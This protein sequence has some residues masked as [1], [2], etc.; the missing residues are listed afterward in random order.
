MSLKIQTSIIVLLLFFQYAIS[1]PT[2]DKIHH[3]INIEISV[4]NGTIKV[5][6]TILI[7]NQLWD[8]NQDYTFL[9]NKKLEITST[10][11]NTKLSKIKTV[12]EDSIAVKYKME[13][14]DRIKTFAALI[15]SYSG[16]I[17]EG[18]EK[19]STEYARGFK[20]TNGIVSDTGVYLAGST[21]WLPALAMADLVTFTLRT[22]INHE[23]SVVS[24]GK[25]ILN[26]ESETLRSITYISP[27]PTD[28]VYLV[29]NKWTEYD[30]SF[31]KVEIQAFL[32]KPD[33]D[34]AKKYLHA[35][36]GYMKLY[37]KLLGPYPYSKFAL[38]ENFWETGYG[39]PSFT[40]LGP[41]VIR[42]PWIIY[43]SYPHEL[44]HNYWGNSVFVN[45]SQGNWCEGITAYMADHL[46]KEQK[47]EG[48][49]YRRATL[50][51]FTNYVNDGNDFPVSEFVNR[52]NPA[53]E[54]VGY[55]KVLMMNNMLRCMLG[56]ELFLQTY[57]MLYKNYKFSKVGFDD[58][59]DCFEKISKRDLKW[60]FDQW[61]LGKGAPLLSLSD[62]KVTDVTD[63]QSHQTKYNLSFSLS[64]IQ[65]DDAFRLEVPV[66]VYLDKEDAPRLEMLEMT[67]KDK[68]YILSYNKRPLR[69][70]VDPHFDL[71]RKLDKSE[72]PPTLSQLFGLRQT[73]IILPA[74]SEHTEAYK[75]LAEMW[76]Q[77]QEGQ[78]NS[79]TIITDEDI[80]SL[81]A[82]KGVWIIGFKNKYNNIKTLLSQYGSTFTDDQKAA[83]KKEEMDG[84]LV[85]TIPNGQLTAL[86]VGFLAAHDD[87]VI[88]GLSHRL[89]HYGKYS[90]LGFSGKEGSNSL[91]TV[92]PVLHS[93]LSYDIKYPDYKTEIPIT[94]KP[95]KALSALIK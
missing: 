29:A 20:L 76:K 94:S 51:K 12:Q 14:T 16:N 91:K 41:Q 90:L 24:Q 43:S 75:K 57:R 78:N 34:M 85:F 62:V 49:I 61:V 33:D 15:L 56:D 38:V 48:D 68:K 30:T 32:I 2:E 64:Q 77:N 92:L 8:N 40:L 53:Q 79:V 17:N 70:S 73:L 95:R 36:I 11:K 28:D 66:E 82:D 37:N 46:F 81:P 80:K 52:N 35:T 45:P 54:A 4:E 84:A 5:C 59:R 58:I 21:Y 47:G 25:R 9:L 87:E 69:L 31:Q 71:M 67:K 10:G 1:Q 3:Y 83:I 19:G 65:N 22:K 7:P 27:A 26:R 6:D 72:I 55:G 63:I 42:F 86:P 44:L 23:W 74:K 93:P 13:S 89:L 39:M 18:F 88:D 50:E 60:F